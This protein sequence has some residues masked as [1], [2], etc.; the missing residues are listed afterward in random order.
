VRLISE[1]QINRPMLCIMSI[2]RSSRRTQHVPR[3]L[4]PS[5]SARRGIL[6]LRI[7][8]ARYRIG[9]DAYFFPVEEVFEDQISKQLIEKCPFLLRF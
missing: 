7:G 5:T 1:Q 8:R 6:L 3:V 9:C 4:E 2:K